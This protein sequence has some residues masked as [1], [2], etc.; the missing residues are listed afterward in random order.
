MFFGVV[1]F[2]GGDRYVSFCQTNIENEFIGGVDWYVIIFPVYSA[3]IWKI[4]RFAV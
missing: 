3:V 2:E 4:N 1:N